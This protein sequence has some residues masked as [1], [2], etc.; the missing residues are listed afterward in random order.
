MFKTYSDNGLMFFVHKN[1]DFLAIELRDGKVLFQFDLGGGRARLESTQKY[2]DGQ[3]HSV[4]ATRRDQNGLLKVDDVKVAE[5]RSVGDLT[6]LAI[7][8]EIY[9]G[10]YRGTKIY[11]FE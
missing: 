10:G 11:N 1:R 8:E 2:N 4:D 5:G 7:E 9:I 6:Q 3:W